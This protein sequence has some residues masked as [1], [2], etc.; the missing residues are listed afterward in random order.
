MLKEP[1]VPL[2]AVA[3]QRYRGDRCTEL[4]DNCKLGLTTSQPFPS[5]ACY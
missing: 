4:I 1:M 5:G 3:A 2:L